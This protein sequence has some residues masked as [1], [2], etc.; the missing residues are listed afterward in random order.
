M[1]LASVTS[2]VIGRRFT[3]LTKRRSKVLPAN[4]KPASI[5]A[6][7]GSLLPA[8]VPV[9]AEHHSVAAVFSPRIS[10]PSLKITPTKPILDTM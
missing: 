3:Q 1:Y 5:A 10:V 9:A 8:K 6:S 4:T 2:G 7:A